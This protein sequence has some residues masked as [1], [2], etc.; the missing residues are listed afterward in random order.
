MKLSDRDNKEVTY[1]LFDFAK[2][3]SILYKH[4]EE[5]IA[6]QKNGYGPR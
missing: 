1:I 5:F 6:W 4:K 2:N 3:N